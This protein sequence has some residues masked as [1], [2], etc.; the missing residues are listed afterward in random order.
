MLAL[1]DLYQVQ[2]LSASRMRDVAG[3]AI[4]TFLKLGPVPEPPAP[5]P[6]T[7]CW[8]ALKSLFGVD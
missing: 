1:S 3:G 6:H 5:P 2:E 8:Q 4:D 7:S